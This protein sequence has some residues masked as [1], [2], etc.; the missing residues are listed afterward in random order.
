MAGGRIIYTVHT[1][2]DSNWRYMNVY[3][4]LSHRN[5][6]RTAANECGGQLGGG[7]VMMHSGS[8]AAYLY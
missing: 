6:V 8:A 3:G 2:F 5:E 7:Q 1:A 4:F